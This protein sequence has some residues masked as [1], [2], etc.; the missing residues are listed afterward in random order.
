MAEAHIRGGGAPTYM[1]LFT[2]ESPSLPHMKSAHGIDGSF[3]YDN[4][5]HVGMAKGD[6]VASRLGARASS[7]WAS[8]AR[9]GDPAHSSL[10]PWPQYTLDERATMVLSGEPKVENDPMTADR[11]LWEK[12]T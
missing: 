5:E 11:L 6:A 7:A 12:L 3:Y 2:W 8:F 9:S 10:G 1:Y 4:T